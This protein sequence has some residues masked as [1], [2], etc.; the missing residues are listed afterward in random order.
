MPD[1]IRPGRIS[2]GRPHFVMLRQSS[3]AMS[4]GSPELVEGP[5]EGVH[6]RSRTLDRIGDFSLRGQFASA[7]AANAPFPEKMQAAARQL[8]GAG[9]R[10]LHIRNNVRTALVAK[11]DARLSSRLR[12]E[13]AR[14]KA[15]VK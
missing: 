3:R 9:H 7:A 1:P 6:R 8:G 12:L 5:V 11:A 10:N 14:D 4:W 15:G 13:N 2:L